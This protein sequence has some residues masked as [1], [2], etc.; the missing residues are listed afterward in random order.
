MTTSGHETA[1]TDEDELF[2][3]LY[4][5]VTDTQTARY[6]ATYDT[7]ANPPF[8]GLYTEEDMGLK[9]LLQGVT[10]TDS[11]GT[12][13]SSYGDPGLSNIARLLSQKAPAGTGSPGLS[14]QIEDAAG[15]LFVAIGDSTAVQVVWTQLDLHAVAG[16]DADVVAAHLA[17]DVTEHIVS[18]V[19][20]DPEHRVGES[21]GDLSL[22]FDLFLFSHAAGE[23]T[24][25][26][27]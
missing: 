25:T 22:H 17:G 24:S 27:Q 2:A 18:V 7:D 20:F 1:S 6:A 5:Q 15:R 10:V 11:A 26:A 19:Q 16:Q 13:L 9:S 14:V 3:R 8:L 21:L 23:R 4:R 12:P